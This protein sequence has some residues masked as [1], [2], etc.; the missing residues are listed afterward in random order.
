VFVKPEWKGKRYRALVAGPNIGSTFAPD[1]Q[2][3]ATG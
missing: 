3:I 2:A 1:A